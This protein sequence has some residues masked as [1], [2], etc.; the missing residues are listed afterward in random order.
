MTLAVLGEVFGAS[1]LGTGT[2]RH[3]Q[4]VLDGSGVSNSAL[5][6]ADTSTEGWHRAV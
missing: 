3:L 6:R 1:G 5:L 4:Y 2:E